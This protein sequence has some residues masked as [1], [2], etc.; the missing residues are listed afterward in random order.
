ME[1]TCS[2]LLSELSVDFKYIKVLADA[3]FPFTK[4]STDIYIS[5]IASAGS[6]KC[7]LKVKESLLS[8]LSLTNN[9]SSAVH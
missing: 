2:D 3:S 5:T 1:E 4:N 7:L 8:N 9:P 6:L